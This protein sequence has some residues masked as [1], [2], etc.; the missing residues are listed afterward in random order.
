MPTKTSK[1]RERK[2]ANCGTTRT[3]DLL[4][5]GRGSTEFCRLPACKQAAIRSL[6]GE[7]VRLESSGG[8]ATQ[9]AYIDHRAERTI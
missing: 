9:L 2:C 4:Y 1:P 6:R 5:Q 7:R 3:A 8:A